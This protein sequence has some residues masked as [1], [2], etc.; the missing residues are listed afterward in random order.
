VDYHALT[1]LDTFEDLDGRDPYER[2][3][4]SRGK[5]EAGRGCG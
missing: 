2:Q 1:G 5:V 4:A 3:S